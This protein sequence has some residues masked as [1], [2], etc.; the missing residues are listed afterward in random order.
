MGELSNFLMRA[1]GLDPELLIK[2]AYGLEISHVSSLGVW[3]FTLTHSFAQFEF[4]LVR[5]SCVS[6]DARALNRDL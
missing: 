4:D 3:L 1:A 6:V 5:I 2:L